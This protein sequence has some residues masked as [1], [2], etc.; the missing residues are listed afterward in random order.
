MAREPGRQPPADD[1]S[2]PIPEPRDES[3]PE[4][5]QRNFTEL[6]QE[7]RV[8]Q[9]GVQILFA[10]LLTLAFS[11]RFE[12]ADD[13][14]RTTYLVA[15]LTAAAATA[16]LIA[17]VAYHRVLFRL[18]LKPYLVRTAHRLAAGGLA[19][20][21][22]AMVSSVMLAADLVVSRPV[23]AVV[24][25]VTGAW[26]VWFWAVAPWRIRRE[27]LREGTGSSGG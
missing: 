5:W 19:L 24:A 26:F 13:F 15:M 7:L 18:G 11:S 12:E 10:F 4:R 8:A 27:L 25:A 21:L 2:R 20:L 16:V 3:E 23:A 22:V 9:M 17:P 6:L 1:W 14:A